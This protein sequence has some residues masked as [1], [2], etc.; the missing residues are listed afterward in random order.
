MLILDDLHSVA[1]TVVNHLRQ[2]N[3]GERMNL[4]KRITSLFQTGTHDPVDHIGYGLLQYT[5][6]T[7]DDDGDYTLDPVQTPGTCSVTGGWLPSSRR[8]TI[9]A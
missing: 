1:S 2:Q 9:C 5:L 3:E 7:I 8:R 4:I 6:E